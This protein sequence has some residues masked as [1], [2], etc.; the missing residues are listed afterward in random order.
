MLIN[1]VN[2]PLFLIGDLA[3]PL[4]TWLMKPFPQSSVLTSEIM[5]FNYRIS[6]ARIVDENTYCHLK[7]RWQQLMK[8]SDMHVDHI[9]N[10]IAVACILHNVCEVYREH[11]NDAWLLDISNSN[12][13]QPPTVAIR[14]GSSN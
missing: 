13:P 1:G 3:Y 14:D 10:V 9:P 11:F 7:A 5:Q 8:R 4:Q 6:R 12:Y 2:V